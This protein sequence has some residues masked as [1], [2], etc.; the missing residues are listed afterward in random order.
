MRYWVG[1]SGYSYPD[2]VGP[3]YPQG[4]RGP[5]MLNHYCSVFPLVEL[6]FTYY[7]L[8]T[9]EMLARLADQTPRGFQFLVKAPKTISHEESPV[10]V[11]AFRQAVLEMRQRDC[12]LGILCQLPQAA[13]QTKQRW[14]WLEHL[15][16]SLAGLGL[17][18][19]FRHRSWAKPTVAE[20][21]SKAQV[22]LVSVDVPALP[23]LYP[24]GLVQSTERIYLRLHSR[25]AENWYRS[26]RDRYDYDFSDHEMREWLDCLALAKATTQ[27]AFVLFN[28]CHHAQAAANA[29]RFQELLRTLPAKVDVVEPP[30]SLPRQKTLFD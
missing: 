16:D 6:N 23:D 15:F 3:F 13:H 18:V 30:E 4:T 26:D 24:R 8:P 14:R 10:D 11:P 22:D 1:T 9:P 5:K 28:N 2:W 7:R 17:A 29:R 25:N 21:L 19:E 12:L 27:Q 20:R